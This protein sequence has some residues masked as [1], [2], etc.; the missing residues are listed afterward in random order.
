[1]D[2][3]TV[4]T[5][6]AQP[7]ELVFEYL[8]DIANHAEFSD[9][10][11]V[12]WHMTRENT[13]GTG[14]GARFRIKA[15]LNRFSWADVTFAELQPPFRIVERGRGGKYNRIRMLGTYTLSPG[16][17]GTTKVEY[18]LETEPAQLSDKL[19][20]HVRR[21]L[22]EPAPGGQGDAR[23]RTI[24]EENRDRGQRAS[25][26][27]SDAS[28]TRP[29]P[30]TLDCAPVFARRLAILVGTLALALGL[31]ACGIGH[32][33]AHPRVADANNNGGYVDAGPITYQL[34][35]SRVLNPY[36]TEDSQYVKGLPAGTAGPT[37]TQEWYGVFLWAKNQTSQPQTTTTRQV[38]HHRHPGHHILPGEARPGGEPVRLDLADAAAA[39]RSS[40]DLTPPPASAP[41]RASCCCSRSAPPPTPT[42]P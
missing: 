26:D 8:A 13:Y 19:L 31:T 42:G 15:P 40:P 20:R 35:I 23:L 32:K 36:A 14:A 1:M 16:P 22:L 3:F 29:T 5:T 7:R 2:P 9:H 4:S 18:T 37:A 6:I 12:D 28:A 17:G 41:P 30:R 25:V 27:S 21:P 33:E 39:G 10:Y 24:L 11:L 38:R 34:Q